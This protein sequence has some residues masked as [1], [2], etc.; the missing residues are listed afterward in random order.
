MIHRCP[1][2]RPQLPAL[3]WVALLLLVACGSDEGLYDSDGDGSLDHEDCA[4]ADPTVHPDAQDPY[5]DG[6][7]QDCDGGDGI[8]RDGDGYPLNVPD[9]DPLGDCNDSDPDVHP[10]ATEVP[11]DGVDDDCDGSDRIDLDGDGFAAVIEDCDDSDPSAFPGADEEPDGAD[12]DCDGAVDEGTVGADD[13]GDGYCEGHPYDGG[14]PGC[15]GEALPGDCDDDSP[16][17]H[18]G[19]TELCDEVDNDCVDGI[20]DDELDHDLDGWRGCDG[21]CDDSSGA[22]HPDAEEAACD[23]VDS[24]C[25]PDPAEVDDDAD[26]SFGCEGDCDD[27]D[28]GLN[29]DDFD[30]DGWDTCAGD[31]DDGDPDRHP[32]HTDY[33]CDGVESNCIFDPLEVDDDGD[34]TA[35]CAGDC[36]DADPGLNNIDSDSDGMDLCSGDCD[37]ADPTRY[38]GATESCDGFDS[39][40]VFDADEVDDDGDGASDCAGDCDDTDPLLS[41]A[42]ADGD[43]V[44]TC[45]NDCDDADPSR[46]PG[47]PAEEPCDGLDNDCVDDP[48]ELDDDGDGW[49][50]CAGDCDD[51][52]PGRFPGNWA[53]LPGDSY[54]GNCDGLDT[55]D[56]SGASV[57][58][59]GAAGGN[60]AGFAVS[61]VGDVDG[62]GLADILVGAPY[63]SSSVALVGAAYLLLGADLTDS[64]MID[65]QQA[66][67]T[68]LGEGWTDHAGSTMAAAGDLDGDGFGDLLVGALE[69]SLPDQGHVGTVYLVLGGDLAGGG[70]LAL[71]DAAATITGSLDW[72]EAGTAIASIDDVTGDGVRDV[73]VG[74]PGQG[75]QSGEAWLFDGA[76][77]AA[78]GDFGRDDAWTVFTGEAPSDRAGRSVTGI[79]DLD[80]DGLGDLAIGA[81]GVDGGGDGAGRVYI[82]LGANLGSSL[83]L[84]LD[85][86]DWIL[87]GEAAGDGAGYS[88]AAGDVDGDGLDDLLIGAPGRD[89]GGSSA[90]GGHLVLATSL[91]TP[92]VSSLAAADLAFGGEDPDDQA[93]AAIAHAGDVDGDGLADMVVGARFANDPQDCGRAYV[94]LGAS[95]ASLILAGPT[96]VPLADSDALFYGEEYSD[97]AGMSV[98]GAGDVDGDGRDDLLVGAPLRDLNFGSAGAAYLLLSPW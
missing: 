79:G 95:L 60:R 65:L 20:P 6:L 23:G 83:L 73:V 24:D 17:V 62:D 11:N 25:V 3:V 54:D 47:N 22:I 34:G 52:D 36:D 63:H 29:P 13:D 80:G 76:V 87:D 67:A 27:S 82:F 44:D 2:T 41:V 45:S 18:P 74:V 69:R 64:S 46:Y 10:G 38:P 8:D 72:G 93:G 77:L 49:F 1:W 39:D 57:V 88:L 91:G 71:A 12:D 33:V 43:G 15:W 81:S 68:L 48:D 4:P 61:G 56:L 40:C 31:C 42:D 14:E 96:E 98:A 84:G 51:T 59:A 78:G 97:I 92:G 19:A 58:M 32:Y 55:F 28:P 21:D 53:D 70:S 26:G 16:V 9:T 35:E 75:T 86:A 90:G 30:S 94:L 5:G 85:Q 66:H 50:E 7:D 37:D 89:V